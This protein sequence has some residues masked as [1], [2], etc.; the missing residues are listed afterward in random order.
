M[1]ML[2]CPLVTACAMS[3]CSSWLHAL[4]CLAPRSC[5]HH[6][7]L[8]LVAA[9]TASPCPL[10]L[11]APH[12]L[13]PRSCTHHITLPLMAA[14]CR[15][16]CVTMLLMQAYPLLVHFISYFS[17]NFFF[18][19]PVTALSPPSL[20]TDVRLSS[21]SRACHGATT[22]RDDNATTTMTAAAAPAAR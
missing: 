1:T 8:P 14:P 22:N 13:A 5:T 21:P 6:V 2:A 12:R 3:P 20:P 4:P 19:S 17:A 16:A 18:C 10:Q 7:A 11:H 15:C 9:C